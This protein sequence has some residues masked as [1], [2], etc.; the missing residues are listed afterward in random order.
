MG[1]FFASV[2]SID[3]KSADNAQK[4]IPSFAANEKVLGG[5]GGK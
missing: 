4:K 5:K 2:K 1:A 3:K